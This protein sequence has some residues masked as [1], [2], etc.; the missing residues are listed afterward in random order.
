VVPLRQLGGTMVGVMVFAEPL[1]GLAPSASRRQEL[2]LL[3]DQVVP[4]LSFVE[5]R[6]RLSHLA[7]HDDLTGLRNRRDLEPVIDGLARTDTGVAVLMCDLDHFKATNDRYGHA[8][9]DRVL[10]RFADLL[11]AHARSTDLA[12]RFGGEEFC[13]VLPATRLR[14]AG[15][16]AERLRAATPGWLAE[17]VPGQ[18]VSIGFAAVDDQHRD[19]R[20]LLAGADS[21]LYAA[22]AAGRD[23][24]RPLL[25]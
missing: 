24:C 22:K 15:G 5:N 7:S 8:T 21:A 10:E 13:L 19:A 14:H 9:G 17:L 20:A 4:A 11:R 18:T 16:I 12:V 1:D 25:D 6:N 2:R 3:A 23:R